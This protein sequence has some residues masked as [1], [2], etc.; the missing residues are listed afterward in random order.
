M[1]IERK[2]IEGIIDLAIKKSINEYKRSGLLKE[3]NDV[4][5]EDVSQILTNYYSG[6]LSP[7]KIEVVR[8]AIEE[9]RRNMY[10]EIIPQYYQQAKTIET[11]AEYFGVDVST[12]VRNKKRLCLEIYAKIF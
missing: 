9:S 10:F 2:E 3:S 6:S 8:A 12:I 5:Y 1:E 4:I 11:I 7:E